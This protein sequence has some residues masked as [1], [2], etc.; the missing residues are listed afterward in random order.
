VLPVSN[1]KATGVREERLRKMAT[2]AQSPKAWQTSFGVSY[3]T[4]SKLKIYVPSASKVTKSQHYI[5]LN[6]F[7]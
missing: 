7:Q 5:P 1:R 3:N 2:E 4:N 6:L